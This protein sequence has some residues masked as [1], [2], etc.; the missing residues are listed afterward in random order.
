MTTH[1]VP[2]PP[3]ARPHGPALPSRFA[4]YVV[5]RDGESVSGG[6]RSL[7]TADLPGRDAVARVSQLEQHL[8][9]IAAEVEASG[10]LQHVGAM[11]D[12]ARMPQLE[13]LTVR[14]WEVLSRLAR[15]QRVPTIAADMS[16]SQSTVRNH[17][18]AIFERFGVHSQAALLERLSAPP[19]NV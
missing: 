4:A 9:R 8:W 12:P 5:A 16:I 6:V 14:Q 13:A 3:P 17:L 7:S 10:V 1:A 18:S 19:Q 11:P 15:G 2:S